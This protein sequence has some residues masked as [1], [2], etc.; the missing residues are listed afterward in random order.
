M[1]NCHCWTDIRH[2]H[3]SKPYDM[4]EEVAQT[5]S[6]EWSNEQ[7]GYFCFNSEVVPQK[8]QRLVNTCPNSWLRSCA[9]TN[10]C[11]VTW[12]HKKKTGVAK[13]GIGMGARTA[14]SKGGMK[15]AQVD[16]GRLFW[17]ISKMKIISFQNRMV[18]KWFGLPSPARI[19]SLVVR[20]CLGEWN[21]PARDSNRQRIWSFTPSI[22][23]N[24][25]EFDE[26]TSNS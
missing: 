26:L 18:P 24:F 17:K 19:A 6:F 4:S 21:A 8:N 20:S 15:N 3:Y 23:K 2:G 12:H 7:N 14:F 25:V 22:C 16:C 10:S 1:A 11:H 5:G 9:N 13:R